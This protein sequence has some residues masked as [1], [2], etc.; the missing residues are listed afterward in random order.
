[1]HG[2]KIEA[3]REI[4]VGAG[5]CALTAPQLFDQ[6]ADDGRVLVLQ[7]SPSPENDDAMRQAVLL[8]PSGALTLRE[9]PE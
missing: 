1:M 2:L 6:D 3:D 4:C 9:D 8:C 7:S 5:L